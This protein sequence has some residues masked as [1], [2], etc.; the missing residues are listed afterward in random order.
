MI[1]LSAAFAGN[2]SYDLLIRGGAVYDGEREEPVVMDIG[3]RGDRI[4]GLGDLSGSTAS[5]VIEAAGLAVS[6]GFIDIH[7]H[8]DFNSFLEPESAH[9]LLQGVTTEVAGNCGMSAAPLLGAGRKTVDSV[10]AREGVAIPERL[11]WEGV[12]GYFKAA[13]AR[14]LASNLVFLVGH[15][16]IRSAVMGFEPR[17]ATDQELEAMSVLLRDAMKEG[18]YGL[19]LGLVYLPG[20]YADDR[21]LTALAGEV[22]KAGGILAVHMRSEGKRLIESLGETLELQRE[23][24]VTL[25]VS[26]LKAAGVRNWPK[27]REAFSLLEAA[28]GEGRPVF[29]DA[30]PYEAAFA[31]LGVVLPEEIYQAPDRVEMLRDPAQRGFVKQRTQE[32]FDKSGVSLSNLMVAKASLPEHSAYEG[33]TI[34]EIAAKKKQE[35]LDFLLD[36]LAEE[37]FKVSAFS[38]S[39]NPAIVAE[40]VAKDYVSIGSD[41]VAD[42]GPKPH[43]RCYGTFPRIIEKFVRAERTMTLGAAIRK[44]TGLPARVL[45]LK[46]RGLV[47]PGYF[48]DLVIFDPAAMKSHA[49]YEDPARPAA[50]VR[51]LLVNGRRVVEGGR[52]NGVL[53]GQ[54]L[55]KEM[56]GIAAD[57]A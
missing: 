29:A 4:A 28:R 57:M 13:G 15:G 9:K 3:I 47:R 34:A 22:R 50:G 52:F 35:P 2:E 30:Y 17:P 19:S 48:A 44:M 23:T 10:W 45:G 7:T 25:E 11:P 42:F 27:I 21:E 31:E 6:P 51:D 53:A 14:G 1:P 18:A 55:R 16:N 43:P 26:H 38:F 20:I 5:E 33:K 39:Q 41:S 56:K 8:S 54:A 12:D 32:E 24:G 37:N 36:F 46:E 49:S 40:V